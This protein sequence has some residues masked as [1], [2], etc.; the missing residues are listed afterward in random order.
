MNSSL[1]LRENL[2]DI[3][4]KAT[5]QAIVAQLLGTTVGACLGIIFSGNLYLPIVA[6]LSMSQIHQLM[7][8]FTCDSFHYDIIGMTSVGTYCNY[9]A[10]SKVRLRTLNWQRTCRLTRHWITTGCLLYHI[11]FHSF[12]SIYLSAVHFH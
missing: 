2:A 5:S 7:I 9:K 6:F 12:I 4:A 8:I 3:T 10:L 11:I 1:G